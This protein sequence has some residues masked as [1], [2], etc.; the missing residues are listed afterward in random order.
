MV[1]PQGWSV[2]RS[3]MADPDRASLVRRTFE[4]YGTGRYTK[5]QL[6]KHQIRAFV[7]SVGIV[8]TISSRDR[9]HPVRGKG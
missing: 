6:L 1:K 9:T 7:P 3:L 5:E 2:G 4:E 8:R